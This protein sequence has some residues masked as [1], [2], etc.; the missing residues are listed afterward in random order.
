METSEKLTIPRHSE[1][2]EE[3]I[4]LI[5]KGYGFFTAF[6]MTIFQ[7]SYYGSYINFKK[8]NLIQNEC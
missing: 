1:R 8:T 3:S 4:L 7:M 6:R 2:S 5:F